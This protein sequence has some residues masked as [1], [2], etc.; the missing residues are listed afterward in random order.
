MGRLTE[1]LARLRQT[2]DDRRSSRLNESAERTTQEYVRATSVNTMI[3]GF[4]SSRANQAQVDAQGRE[5]FVNL[6]TSSVADLLDKFSNQH[7]TTARQGRE[8]RASFVAD[9]AKKTADFIAEFDANHKEA[10][11][12]AAKDRSDFI[13][14]LGHEVASLLENF[15]TTRN[16]QANDAAQERTAFF[17]ELASSISQFLTETQTSRANDAKLSAEERGRFVASLAE[18]VSSQ[19]EAL[20]QAHSEMAKSTSEERATFVSN[21]A[22][23]VAALIHEAASDRGGANAAFFG[24]V[25]AEKKNEIPKVAD[26]QPEVIIDKPAIRETSEARVETS[27][28]QSNVQPEEIQPYNLIPQVTESVKDDKPES[29]TLWDSLVV[30][31]GKG[32][33]HEKP[34]KKHQGTSLEDKEE[35]KSDEG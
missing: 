7:Q 16:T 10:S 22:S 14:N 1:D 21:L 18:Q 23:N 15:N 25:K 19:L 12:R 17:K 35:N 9:V 5:A 8:E 33:D 11:E 29:V 28:E 20:N 3:A 34:R 30:K 4:A 26:R 31:K 24:G 2:I 27:K 13:A 32:G 6:N